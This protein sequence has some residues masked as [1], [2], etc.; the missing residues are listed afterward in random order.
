MRTYDKPLQLISRAF[1]SMAWVATA[2]G[3]WHLFRGIYIR[4]AYM[5]K[6]GHSLHLKLLFDSVSNY[7][8]FVAVLLLIS[9]GIRKMLRTAEEIAEIRRRLEE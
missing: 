1:I 5:D 2:T 6:F 7:A 8:L 9:F 4:L 3:L